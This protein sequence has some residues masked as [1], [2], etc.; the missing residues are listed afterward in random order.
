MNLFDLIVIGGGPAGYNA[1]AYAAGKGLSV[2]LF[3]KSNLG[4]VCLNEG[5]VPSKTLLNSAKIYSYVC[6]SENYGV[7]VPDKGSVCQSS[8]ID[9]KNKVVKRLVTGVRAKLKGAGVSV[10]NAR[11]VIKRKT[12]EGFEVTADGVDYLSKYLLLATGSWAVIPPI[13]G[14]KEG[15]ESSYVMTNREILDI[16]EIPASLA[17]IGGGVIGLEMADYYQTVGS[18]VTVIEALD[19]IAGATE[20]KVTSVLKRALEKKGVEFKLNCKVVKI[21]VGKVIYNDGAADKELICEK[22]LMSVGRRAATAELGLENIG[23]ELQ[24]GSVVTNDKLQ[25]NIDGLYAAGDVNGKSMLAHTA[26]REGEVAVNNILGKSDIINYNAIPSVIYTTPE[27]A[28][29]GY[30]EESAVKAGINAKSIT[31][32][33]MYSGR[34]I[35]ENT[36]YTGVCVLVKDVD[37]N[38]LIGAHIVG[39]YASEYIVAVSELIDLEIDIERIKKLVFP[40]PTVCETVREAVFEI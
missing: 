4:G 23:V 40:H 10:V 8:V 25:T 17:I 12:G 27:T 20:D 37:K 32:S 9:R 24:R 18:K 35:A 36:D 13:E 28:S 31:L 30:T 3:E 19:K 6:H 15:L 34:Y 16:R 38:T 11:C 33:L 5:C 22:V 29:V 39:N 1:A 14:V 7:D 26:Y 21:G 2:I